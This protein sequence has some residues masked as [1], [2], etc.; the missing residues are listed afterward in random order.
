[1][2]PKKHFADWSRDISMLLMKKFW[3]DNKNE[4]TEVAASLWILKKKFQS[5]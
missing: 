2:Q 5:Q 1:M 4:G 3:S